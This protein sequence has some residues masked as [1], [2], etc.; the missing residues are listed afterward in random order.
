MPIP[1]IRPAIQVARRS[2]IMASLAF[3]ASLEVT[4]HARCPEACNRLLPWL[5][6]LGCRDDLDPIERDILSTPYR[7][8]EPEQRLDAYWAGEG[9]AIYLWALGKVSDPPPACTICDHHAILAIV[10][11]LYPEAQS[12]IDAR[13]LRSMDEIHAYSGQVASMR[14]EFQR[15]ALDES[16]GETLL[17]IRRDRLA[18]IGLSMSDE[19]LK[20][21]C[22]CIDAMSSN[23]KKSAPGFY[24]VR[25]HAVSWL[26]DSRTSYFS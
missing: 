21:A 18:E 6:G 13:T 9:A 19:D 23:E 20:S 3:R 15:R 2:I 11:V 12:I 4:E 22:A 25:E 8:L 14:M 5:D 10:R 1:Q 7:R 16:A 17:K 24:F 26:F